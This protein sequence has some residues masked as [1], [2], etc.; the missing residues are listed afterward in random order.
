[1]KTVLPDSKL[2]FWINN[3]LNVLLIGK[4]G[5]GK[6]EKIKGAIKRNKIKNALYF[7]CATLDPW[8]DF[9]GVPKEKEKDGV[10]YLGLV[11]P[12]AFATGD[13]EFIFLDELN[14][15]K[16][17]VQNAVLELINSG[18]INGKKFKNL[19]CIMAAINPPA[20]KHT[21]TQ[22]HTEDLDPAMITRFPIRYEVPFDLDKE[23]FDKAHGKKVY[24]KLRPWW[25][26]LP[27]DLKDEFPPRSIDY[28]LKV[29]AL[30]GDI[31]DCLPE[32]IAK[33]HFMNALNGKVAATN[34]PIASGVSILDTFNSMDPVKIKQKI[35]QN[36]GNIKSIISG[37]SNEELVKLVKLVGVLGSG[38]PSI[39]GRLIIGACSAE[40][41]EALRKIRN[42][43]KIKQLINKAKPVV[44]PSNRLASDAASE[45]SDE[46]NNSE[47]DEEYE[48]YGRG[49]N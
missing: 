5:I 36:K 47:E 38:S 37:L 24:E 9:I 13:V 18:S 33:V 46:D 16:P 35:S 11:R 44:G 1:M 2:D 4:H 30:G 7:S 45:I 39:Y 49:I 3:C 31:S 22:Y 26:A 43:P 32:R 29:L 14:R 10:Q 40:Q 27:E 17:A 21:D 48:W 28:T 8:V 23:Y 20:K 42:L 34:N 6:T 12:K 15:A 19:R 41:Q 25:L